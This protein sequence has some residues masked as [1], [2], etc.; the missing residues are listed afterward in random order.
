MVANVE[1][2]IALDRCGSAVDIRLSKP[3][4]TLSWEGSKFLCL[5]QYCPAHIAGER[6][7]RKALLSRHPFSILDV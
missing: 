3:L 6:E 4:G 1:I 5:G 2:E 7:L